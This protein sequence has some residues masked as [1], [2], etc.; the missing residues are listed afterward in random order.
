DDAGNVRD[1]N[2][3]A[4]AAGVKLNLAVDLLVG[5]RT[6]IRPGEPALKLA[7]FMEKLP[8]VKLAGIQAYVG[9]AAHI[10][11]FEQRKKGSLEAMAAAV[12]TRRR[13][14]RS[15]IACDWLSG[16]STGTYN[17][18]SQIDGVTELQP[19]SF[20]F[21]DL[22]Y[23]R[24]GGQNGEIY[25]D[26]QSALTVLTTVVSKTTTEHAV[27]DGGLK[28]FS[29]DRKFGPKAKG[30]E[31]VEYSWGGDEHGK[32][33][34]R[35]AESEVKLGDRIE[36]F[37]PHCDPTVNLYDHMFCLRGEKVEAVWQIAARGKSQ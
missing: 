32:L 21:M 37:V 35:Q 17:I 3:A 9:P 30:L 10:M 24:I 2:D 31:N 36:F 7:Q 13:F 11:G 26:F 5:G 12:E 8:H 33:D 16:A 18:D 29:T 6:G 28:A 15:G 25:D 23:S 4:G 1:L 22:D 27:V 19:G 34:L 14:E 20:M